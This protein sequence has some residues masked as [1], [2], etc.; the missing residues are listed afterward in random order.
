M[1]DYA[2]A[3]PLYRQALE[4]RKQVLGDK[5]PDYA[6]SL[7]NLAGLYE[8]MGDYAKAEPLFRQALAID[9]EALGDKHPECAQSL[10]N[11]AA[12]YY[13]MGY[14]AK[15]EP[16]YRQA[17]GITRQ[18]LLLSAAVQSERQQ[19]RMGDRLRYQLDSYL[20]TVVEAQA[21]AKLASDTTFP[22]LYEH[23]L[24]W[25]GAVFMQQ[26]RQHLARSHPELTPL[27]DKLQDVSRRL[28][29]RAL[30]VPTPQQRQTWQ[31][32]I[33]DLTHEKE[34]LESDLA[35]RSAAFDR[36]RQLARLTAK[37]L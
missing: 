20:T 28:A 34:R 11:L 35:G 18:S 5:H 1:G 29:T 37:E 9:K 13:L 27:F 16:L 26:R 23:I 19:M 36:D 25:E 33:A 17:L 12:L 22:G 7:N 10:S 4:I 21:K 14:H 8:L 2:K 3:E 24:A 31:M 30:A 6:T 15:T 32:D